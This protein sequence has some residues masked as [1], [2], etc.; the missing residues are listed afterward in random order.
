[1]KETFGSTCHGAGRAMS[2]KAATRRYYGEDVKHAL[3]KKGE[4]IRSIS[5][6]ILAEEAPNAYKDVHVVVDSVHGA[7]ISRRAVRRSQFLPGSF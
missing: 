5:M 2:R 1:M 4:V 6:K 7:D 3:E